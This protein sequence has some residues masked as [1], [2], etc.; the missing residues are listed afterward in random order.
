[1]KHFFI[2]ILLSFPLILLSQNNDNLLS[3]TDLLKNN[4]KKNH[5]LLNNLK[6]NITFGASVY[7]SYGGNFINTFIAPTI[8]LPLNSKLF[9]NAGI[10]YNKSFIDNYRIPLY[11][12]NTPPSISNGTLEQSVFFASIYYKYTNHL[13]LYA[14]ISK[15]KVINNNIIVNNDKPLPQNRFNLETESYSFGFYYKTGKNS[16]INFQINFDRNASPYSRNY[17]G[18]AFSPLHQNNYIFT[19]P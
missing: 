15:S 11:Y 9:I 16:S 12:D 18:T 8:S 5:L 1:M 6:T 19:Q 14:S 2:N 3:D 13:T 17:N 10:S 7:G 4:H